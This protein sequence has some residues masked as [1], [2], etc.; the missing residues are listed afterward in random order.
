MRDNRSIPTATVIPELAY[1]DVAAAVTWLCDAFGF[2]ERLRIGDHR[3]QLIYGSGALVV[4]DGSRDA[5]GAS[6]PSGHAVLVRVDDVDAHHARAAAAGAE[7]VSPPTTYP[8]GE[9]QYGALDLGGHRWTFS[10]T[11]RDVDPADW[12]GVL[13]AGDGH[14]GPASRRR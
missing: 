2:V 13:R 4:T 7:I 3:A 8:F 12:G 11:V 1:A 10:Q 9:R 6:R 14:E 5:A